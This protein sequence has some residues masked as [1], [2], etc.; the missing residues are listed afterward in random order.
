MA[1]RLAELDQLPGAP[2]PDHDGA[3]ERIAR[4]SADLAEPARS[5]AYEQAGN[6]R[7]AFDV[8]TAWLQA[9]ILAS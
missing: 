6:G 1:D 3:A 9:K 8:A 7:R 5:R 2:D 4:F